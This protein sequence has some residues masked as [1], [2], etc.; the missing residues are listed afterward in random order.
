MRNLENWIKYIHPE[1]LPKIEEELKQITAHAEY[2][3]EFRILPADGNIR[4]IVSKGK[5]FCA[6]G[7][8]TRLVGVN[9]DI[10]D[11]KQNELTLRFQKSLLEAQS[12]ASLDGI[13][14]VALSGEVLSYNRRFAEMWEISEDAL[15]AKSDEKLLQAVIDKLADPQGFLEH[16]EYLYQNPFIKE[17]MEIVLKD[18]RIFERYSAPVGGVILHYSKN[19][20]F[21]RTLAN[22]SRLKKHCVNRKNTIDCCSTAIRCRCGFTTLNHWT[23]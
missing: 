20:V 10:T 4:W 5:T 22:A 9:I 19:L 17:M 15:A 12:E 6:E 13:L 1:D 16:I 8:A 2:K 3:S 21:S 18:N 14:V 11:R 7:K 23:F